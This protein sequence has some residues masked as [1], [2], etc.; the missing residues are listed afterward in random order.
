MKTSWLAGCR[1]NVLDQGLAIEHRLAVDGALAAQFFQQFYHSL[2]AQIELIEVLIDR[3]P[4]RGTLLDVVR[5]IRP[6][7][8]GFS[9]A[10]R[11]SL[12]THQEVAGVLRGGLHVGFGVLPILETEISSR[13]LIEEPLVVCLPVGHSLAAKSTVQPE[14]LDTEPL[15]SVSRKGLPGRHAE[16]VTHFESL[17]VSLRFVSD[18]YSEKEA[19][20]LVTQ[21]TGVSLMTKGSAERF[22][23]RKGGPPPAMPVHS[24]HPRPIVTTL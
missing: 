13:L 12:M 9:S 18:A 24:S 10:T 23:S 15:V 5:R 1:A 17:G 22:P 8:I 16:I 7:A 2:N 21:G 14:D 19:L 11:E 6:E 3:K 4:Q 20:W